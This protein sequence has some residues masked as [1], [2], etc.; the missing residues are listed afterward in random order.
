MITHCS[1]DTDAAGRTLGLKP[2]S[3]IDHVAM[4]VGSIGNRIADVDP[5]AKPNYPIRRMVAIMGGHLLLHF[6]STTH[7]PVDAIEYD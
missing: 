7:R 6:Y 4:Q 3:D 1:R 2:R 5:D